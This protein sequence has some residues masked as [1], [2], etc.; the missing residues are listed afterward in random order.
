MATV[1]KFNLERRLSKN[2]NRES[3]LLARPNA[4]L[5]S[6]FSLLALSASSDPL[7]SSASLQQ[8]CDR[9]P[10]YLEATSRIRY[11]NND[12]ARVRNRKKIGSGHSA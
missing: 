12:E 7:S 9:T 2:L 3:L 10:V 6:L 11:A 8:A 1:G 5:Q 4:L